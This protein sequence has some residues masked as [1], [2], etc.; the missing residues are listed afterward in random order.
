MLG[1]SVS[2]EVE[3]SWKGAALPY[4]KFQSK[5]CISS[6]GFKENLERNQDSHPQG[7]DPVASQ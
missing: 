7:L 6:A 3:M 2:N 1:W 5:L 4:V